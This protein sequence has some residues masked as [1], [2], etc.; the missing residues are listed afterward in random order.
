MKL[1]TLFSVLLLVL[2][3]CEESNPYA[4][5]VKQGEK[6]E[7]ASTASATGD[8]SANVEVAEGQDEV[9]EDLSE[10][11]KTVTQAICASDALFSGIKAT[12]DV[13]C[14]DGQATVAMAS[15]LENPFDGTGEPSINLLQSDDVNG[16]S[17]F[18]VIS[19]VKVPL[20]PQEVLDRSADINN[21]DAVAGNATVTQ[22]EVSST[23]GDNNPIVIASEVNFQLDVNVGI[24]SVSD[25]RIL[26]R[27]YIMV[28]EETNVFGYRSY[29]KAGEPDNEDNILANQMTLY[30]PVEDG[31]ILIGIS[32]QHTD[33]RGRHAT[34]EETF[35]R[36]ARQTAIDSVDLLK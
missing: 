8:N 4:G 3:G 22:T 30:V 31:T 28:D 14:V 6:S 27:E 2:L 32:Q 16:V 35:N 18:M 17:E 36:L 19:S 7:E 13:A 29:L 15:A 9:A 1:L 34:A 25:T 33:N 5:G 21:A 23:P 20:T 10:E 26:V 11:A 24:I 12:F